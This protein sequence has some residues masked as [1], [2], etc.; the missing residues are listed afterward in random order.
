VDAAAS[1]LRALESEGARGSFGFFE[2]VDYTR[3]RHIIT[4]GKH[5]VQSFFAHHQG[6]SLVSI[7][8]ALN[9][10]IMCERFHSQPLVK[11]AELLLHERFPDRVSTIVPHEPELQAVQREPEAAV[12]TPGL[13]VITSP[14]TLAPRVRVLSN[15]SYSVVVDSA[16]GGFSTFEKGIMLTRWREDPTCT[17]SGSFI[18]VHDPKKRKTWSAAYQPTKAEPS[19]YEAIFSP[20]RAEFK[21][22]DDKVFVHTEI[23]VAPEDNVELRRVTVTNLGDSERELD[24]VSYMEPVLVSRKADAAHPAFNKLFVGVEALRDS[25]AILCSRR[26]RC[27]VRRRRPLD[28]VK[29]F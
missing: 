26:P 13:E 1:N 22:F 4:E 12:E 23:T 21:R 24:I 8:N 9:D 19:S 11:S 5:I 2:A 6:M 14:N 3:S 27:R 29:R 15:G 25:D 10:R 7:N 28:R 16:G 18:Y 17:D 20:G